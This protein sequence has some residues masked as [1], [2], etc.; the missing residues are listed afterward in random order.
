M[1]WIELLAG[2]VFVIV[3]VLRALRTP[4]DLTEALID[5]TIGLGAVALGVSELAR[6]LAADALV[7]LGALGLVAGSAL[8]LGR[9]LRAPRSRRPG[10]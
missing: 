5:I 4:P 8:L 10:P 3:G 9:R 6:G 1:T 2:T 7:V